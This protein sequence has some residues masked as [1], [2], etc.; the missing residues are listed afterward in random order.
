[1][2]CKEF[3]TELVFWWAFRYFSF[4]VK[5]SIK[6][7]WSLRIYLWAFSPPVLLIFNELC[8]NSLCIESHWLGMPKDPLISRYN[9]FA[10]FGGILLMETA[11]NSFDHSTKTLISDHSWFGDMG[12]SCSAKSLLCGAAELRRIWEPGLA[13]NCHPGSINR[14]TLIQFSAWEISKQ[15]RMTLPS[16]AVRPHHEDTCWTVSKNGTPFGRAKKTTH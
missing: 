7:T 16:P 5:T 1:M 14:F 8:E 9:P 15:G 6:G 4:Q 13:F 3:I 12:G 2:W 10:S 11:K